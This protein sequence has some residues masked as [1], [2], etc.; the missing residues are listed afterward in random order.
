MSSESKS[1][2]DGESFEEKFHQLYPERRG[3]QKIDTSTW[4][5]GNRTSTIRSCEKNVVACF[6]K[7]SYLRH[8]WGAIESHGCKLDLRRHFSCDICEPGEHLGVYDPDTCQ[9]V[10]C[11]NNIAS[12]SAG[13]CCGVLIKNMIEMFDHC[14]YKKSNENVDQLACTEIRKANFSNCNFMLHLTSTKK[15]EQ[16]GIIDNHKNCVRKAATESL[17]KTRLVPEDKAVEA[18]N[19]VFDK[20]YRDLEPVGRRPIS[21][22]DMKAAYEERYLCGYSK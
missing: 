3:D 22:E 15:D 11:A 17:V 18:I 21:R 19:K 5:A 7:V 8:L 13:T 4:L 14:V 10:V 9:N 2:N 6:E 20:C 12:K 1:N 16:F